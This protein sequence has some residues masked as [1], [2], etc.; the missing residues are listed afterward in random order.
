MSSM[1]LLNIDF[2]SNINMHLGGSI[3]KLGVKPTPI[4]FQNLLNIEYRNH[5]DNR[6]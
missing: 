1:K 6:I 2:S 4:L 5:E 3:E